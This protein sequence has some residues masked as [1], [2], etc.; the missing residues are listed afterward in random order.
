MDSYNIFVDQLDQVIEKYSRFEIVETEDKKFLRGELPIID[1]NDERWE[2]YQLEIK[3]HPEFPKRFPKVYEIS[4]KIPKNADW[5]IYEDNS[6]CVDVLPS[7]I[8]KCKD[9]LSLCDFIEKELLPYF[10]NQTHRQIEGYYVGGEYSHGLLGVYEFYADRLKTGD[11][12]RKSLSLLIFIAT[13]QR[14][15]RSNKCFCG[16]GELFRHCHMNAYDE[17]K[18]LRKDLLIEDIKDI[19][20]WSGLKSIDR[21]HKA[22]N[23]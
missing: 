4:N 7:E 11:N 20:T 6:C 2:S 19:Y 14:P 16:S 13:Q 12:I 3:H 10:F 9:G 18:C 22:K 1:K 23:K 17:L 5:H 8:I 15:N 21:L